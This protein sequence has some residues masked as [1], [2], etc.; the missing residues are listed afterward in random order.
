MKTNASF[1]LFF[2]VLTFSLILSCKKEPIDPSVT[3][4]PVTEDP[5]TKVVLNEFTEISSSDIDFHS[6]SISARLL[7]PCDT[8]VKSQG[9]VWSLERNPSLLESESLELEC[10]DG[11]LAAEMPELYANMTYYVKAFLVYEKDTVYSKELEFKTLGIT[12]GM[13]HEGGI[14]VYILKEGDPGYDPFVQHGLIA[15][16]KEITGQFQFGCNF[17]SLWEARELNIG[18][19]KANTQ[20]IISNNCDPLNHAA[21][22]CAEH[23]SEGFGDWHLPSLLEMTEIQK[24]RNLL[25]YYNIDVSY[26]SSSTLPSKAWAFFVYTDKRHGDGATATIKLSEKNVLPIRYF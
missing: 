14:V 12:L 23:E 2:L 9:F 4:E 13:E 5:I 26:W 17:N 8:S 10:I 24:N 19:G 7:K 20:A 18:T 11:Q 21:R 6:A 3:E 25:P 1:Y 15:S 22:V 16:K